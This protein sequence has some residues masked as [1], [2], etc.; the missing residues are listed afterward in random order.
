LLGDKEDAMRRGKELTID[1]LKQGRVYEFQTDDFNEC[2]EFRHLVRIKETGRYVLLIDVGQTN[3]PN[4]V[5]EKYSLILPT[6]WLTGIRE[7]E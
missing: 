1:D 3:F 2:G 4:G 6:R 7:M 5:V